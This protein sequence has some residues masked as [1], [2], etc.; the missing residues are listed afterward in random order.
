MSQ[1]FVALIHDMINDSV[2]RLAMSKRAKERAHPD[3]AGK[4]AQAV[5]DIAGRFEG[6]HHA[7]R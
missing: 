4:I 6:G 2:K 5:L 1:K 3:A 7:S